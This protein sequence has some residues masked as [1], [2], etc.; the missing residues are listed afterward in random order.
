V[1]PP[2]LRLCDQ[3]IPRCSNSSAS[4]TGR[5]T[6]KALYDM[7][8]RYLFP[9]L[10]VT[11]LIV[12][13]SSVPSRLFHD[14]G[15]L[16]EEVLYN[17]AHIPAFALLTY[18]WFRSFSA[19]KTKGPNTN[20]NALILSALIVFAVSDEIHQAYVPGRYASFLDIGLDLIG[21][22]MG[23]ALLKAVALK[24]RISTNLQTASPTMED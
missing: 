22:C 23:L 3:Q 7:N 24:N 2:R 5:K 9:S 17:L 21:I 20:A 8:L 19:R 6:L 1:P 11:G 16:S 12:C 15:T 4:G 18:L 13:L 10:L 14:T